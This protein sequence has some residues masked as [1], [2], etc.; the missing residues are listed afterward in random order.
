MRFLT[1]PEIGRLIAALPPHWRPLIMLLVATGLRWGEAIGLRADRVDLLAARPRLTVVEQLQEMASTGELVFQSPK[2]VKGRRMVSFTKKVALLLAPLI[3]GKA[4]GEVVFT[5][6]KGGLVRTR[7]F[8][9]IWVR[10]CEDAGLPGL[11]IHDLR[12]THAAILISAGR[13]LSAI[14]RR[15]GHSSIVVTDLLYGHLREEVDEGSIAAIEEAMAGVR[16]EDLETEVDQELAAA[17]PLPPTTAPLPET[18]PAATAAVS[19]TREPPSSPA[20]RSA[21][22]PPTKPAAESK[23]PARW[24]SSSRRST[25]TRPF[26]LVGSLPRASRSERGVFLEIMQRPRSAGCSSRAASA[27][28]LAPGSPGTPPSS[29]AAPLLPAAVS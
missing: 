24:S 23:A 22:T 18:S 17:E 7:N 16:S 27:R 5:A 2:T 11:R 12:H 3:A 25:T 9:R 10:A 8:R 4:S 19:V 29:W 20:P 15:L 1:D 6:P 28:L 21:V 13:P 26:S 14:S